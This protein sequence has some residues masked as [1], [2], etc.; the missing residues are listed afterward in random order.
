MGDLGTAPLIDKS[1]RDGEYLVETSAGR[2]NDAGHGA[3]TPST[4]GGHEP[5]P[6]GELNLNFACAVAGDLNS[7]CHAEGILRF[8]VTGG[9][10]GFASAGLWL[11]ITTLLALVGFVVNAFRTGLML[12]VPI[13]GAL[14]VLALLT[15]PTVFDQPNL[16]ADAVILDNT[17]ILDADLASPDGETLS[18]SELLNGHEALLIGLVLPGSNKS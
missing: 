13:L 4:R 17:K 15:L 7:E 10:D 8:E 18:V 16:G 11:T 12:P 5:L 14:A 1:V 3:I 6:V 2:F 9:D